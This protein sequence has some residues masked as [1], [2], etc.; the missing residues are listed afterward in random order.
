MSLLEIP[1]NNRWGL[2][3]YS[4]HKLP[5]SHICYFEF[6]RNFE[7]CM[8]QT[9]TL[10]NN[11]YVY[12]VNKLS[13]LKAFELQNIEYVDLDVIDFIQNAVFVIGL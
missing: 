13:C 12:H 10:E 8:I 6:V 5:I 9:F 3:D 7:S 2:N 11:Y 4:A 1:L